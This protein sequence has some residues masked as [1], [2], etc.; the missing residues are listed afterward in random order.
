MAPHILDKSKIY[1][2]KNLLDIVTNTSIILFYPRVIFEH[3]ATNM[4][5]FGMGFL[6]SI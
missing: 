2:I 6:S 1:K 3:F 5:E 4:I